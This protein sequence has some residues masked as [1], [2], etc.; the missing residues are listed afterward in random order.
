MDSYRTLSRT[1][2]SE[3]TELMDLWG[4]PPFQ[5]CYPTVSVLLLSYILGG[6]SIL[7]I[8]QRRKEEEAKGS[9]RRGRE[10]GIKGWVEKVGDRRR[11]GTMVERGAGRCR[12][13]GLENQS[14]GWGWGHCNTYHNCM[15]FEPSFT[16]FCLHPCN[17]TATRTWE[18]PWL[19]NTQ[20][21]RLHCHRS[22]Q[23]RNN[24][25]WHHSFM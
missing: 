3:D 17:C 4:Y 19:H 1:N 20:G 6:T 14:V 24:I 22:V 7:Y 12:R 23:N 16:S 9:G 13:G 2:S 10:E 11:G 21:W 18:L 5:C 25:Q 15:D 8:A